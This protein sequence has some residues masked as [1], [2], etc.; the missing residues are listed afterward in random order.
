MLECYRALVH[1]AQAILTLGVRPMQHGP[2]ADAEEMMWEIDQASQLI[3][4]LCLLAMARMGELNDRGKIVAK[5]RGY[6]GPKS[7][8]R[9]L[10]GPVSIA[11]RHMA[12][13]LRFYSLF[14]D[15]W[16]TWKVQ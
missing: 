6:N 1:L 13:Q 7:A 2:Q 12:G 15:F 11:L 10:G 14:P 3:L 9:Q 4:Y 5:S 8:E 16:R